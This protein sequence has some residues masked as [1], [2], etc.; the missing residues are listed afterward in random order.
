MDI[1][2]SLTREFES[3]ANTENNVGSILRLVCRALKESGYNPLDQIVGYLISGDPTYIT[4]HCN[5]RVLIRQ[6]DRDQILDELVHYYLG[7]EERYGR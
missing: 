5:A 4:N 3:Q 1:N 2:T 6:L 7:K